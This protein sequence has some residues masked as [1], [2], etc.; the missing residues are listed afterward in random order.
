MPGVEDY[1]RNLLVVQ[2]DEY[3]LSR[4]LGGAARWFFDTLKNMLTVGLLLAIADKTESA[5]LKILGQIASGMLVVTAMAPTRGWYLDPLHPLKSEPV[6]IL[7]A[8][9]TKVLIAAVVLTLMYFEI[10][11][12]LEVFVGWNEK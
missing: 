8:V 12:A 11:P 1:F 6:R 4:V 2:G 7:G 9:T 5:P 10:R 3:W